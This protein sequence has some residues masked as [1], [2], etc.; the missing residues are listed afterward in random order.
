MNKFLSREKIILSDKAIILLVPRIIYFL[1]SLRKLN[2]FFP[3]GFYFNFFLLDFTIFVS[4]IVIILIVI[5][6]VGTSSLVISEALNE[7]LKEAV[8]LTLHS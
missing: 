2:I 6:E 5:F 1:V 7:G 4:I 3:F 8:I